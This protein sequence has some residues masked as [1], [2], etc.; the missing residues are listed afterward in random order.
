M[1]KY[2][3]RHASVQPS[4]I[5]HLVEEKKDECVK[6]QWKL[7]TNKT[8]V[9]VSVR[10]ILTKVADWLDMFK[11][12]GDTAVEYV[13]GHAAIPWAI[14]RALLQ[15]SMR[16]LALTRHACTDPCPGRRE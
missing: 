1:L 5:V 8:G 11:D 6:K 9:Q 4:E 16:Q 14:V 2:A 7:Y 12:V 10:D 3:R 15:V 13:P